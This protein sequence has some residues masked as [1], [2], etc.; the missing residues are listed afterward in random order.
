M[1]DAL[2][3]TD[4][5]AAKEIARALKLATYQPSESRRPPR[6]DRFSLMHSCVSPFLSSREAR[7]LGIRL[8]N[9]SGCQQKLYS[10]FVHG[11]TRRGF[12]YKHKQACAQSGSCATA[13]AICF[14][15]LDD[16]LESLLHRLSEHIAKKPKC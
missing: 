13:S 16:R 3:V 2:R 4:A 12:D 5:A 1:D 14:L 6:K 9:A 8:F 10:H 11:Q 7:D 15:H